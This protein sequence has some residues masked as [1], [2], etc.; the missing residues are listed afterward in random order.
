M[1]QKLKTVVTHLEML[2]PPAY[3]A[4][5]TPKDALILHAKP[6]TV[7]YYRFLYDTVGANWMW[8]ERRKMSDDALRAIVQHPL[9]EV[10]VLHVGGVPAGY[11]ELDRRSANQ[12][13]LAYFGLMPEFIGRGL[14]GWLLRRAVMLAWDHGSPRPSRVWVHTCD[15]DHPSALPL[16]QRVGFRP[17]KE[18]IEIVDDP[19]EV[20]LPRPN[21]VDPR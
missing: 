9:V 21:E 6:P 19:S 17:F 20:M 2:S 8:W 1:A 14:G 15:L 10:H 7:A 3:P 18:E 5:P 16:Y 11:A 4:E 13:E 12:V